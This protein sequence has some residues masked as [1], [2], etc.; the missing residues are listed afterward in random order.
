M[1]DEDGGGLGSLWKRDGNGCA[2]D[3]TSFN[4][5]KVVLPEVDEE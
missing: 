2:G 5:Q 4:V 3:Y 1:P